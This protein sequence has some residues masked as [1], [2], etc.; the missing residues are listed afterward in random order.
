MK[1]VTSM[2]RGR[3][4]EERLF[5]PFELTDAGFVPN[6]TAAQFTPPFERDLPSRLE[7]GARA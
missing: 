7:P 4:L 5:A 6:G 3:F 2:S 1:S